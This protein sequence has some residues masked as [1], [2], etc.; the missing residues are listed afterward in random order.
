[1]PDHSISQTYEQILNAIEGKRLLN[2]LTSLKGLVGMAADWQLQSEL[3]SVTQAY[4]SLLAYMSRGIADEQRDSFHLQFLR[5]AYTLTVRSYRAIKAPQ[6]RTVYYSTLQDFRQKGTTIADI[7]KEASQIDRQI[8]FSN[9]TEEKSPLWQYKDEKER[10][11]EQLFNA[12]WT[13][14]FLTAEEVALLREAFRKEPS[15]LS[16]DNR[17]VLVSAL[18]WSL[19]HFL[20]PEKLKLLIELYLTGSCDV[21][22]RALVGIVFGILSNKRFLPLF[23]ETKR[24]VR[25]F[26][27]APTVGWQLSTLQAQLLSFTKTKESQQAIEEAL[28]PGLI[29]ESLKKENRLNIERIESI[30]DGD[31]EFMT[32]QEKELSAKLEKSVEKISDMHQQG[33]DIFFTTFRNMKR[34]PFFNVVANWFQPFNPE[35]KNLRQSA[36]GKS[37]PLFTLP[38]TVGLCDSDKYSFALMIQSLPM[39]DGGSLPKTLENLIGEIP[40][41]KSGTREPLDEKTLRQSYLQDCY[42]FFMLFYRCNELH[43]PFKGDMVIVREPIFRDIIRKDIKN[44]RHIARFAYKLNDFRLS[45]EMYSLIPDQEWL[46]PED[47]LHYGTS[48]LQTG[49]LSQAVSCFKQADDL[50]PHSI[51]ILQNLATSYRS[52][53]DFKAASL[54]YKE[55]TE[56]APE[57]KSLLFRYGE[58]L[59]LNGQKGDA[60]KIFYKLEYLA[61][62]SLSAK[63]TI[64]WCSLSVG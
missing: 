50:M 12:I 62:D 28:M 21:R 27:T 36:D 1:M 45:A 4:T 3:E 17:Q 16:S 48:L 52:I 6:K 14:D 9:L 38:S 18:S 33:I 13:S 8:L 7:I 41:P 53:G 34:F 29:K 51:T 19:L 58:T 42:R 11:I 5:K 57:S 46:S 61:P 32:P 54:I 55:L 59:F 24:A 35:N 37:N 22:S 40:L 64:A 15:D 63:R 10:K 25:K 49:H 2:A 20:D 39:P 56:L 47:L 30:L 23:P 44:I 60:L 31:R 43:N 26:E